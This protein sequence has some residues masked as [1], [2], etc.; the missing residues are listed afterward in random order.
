[1]RVDL[2]SDVQ[3]GQAVLITRGQLAGLTGILIDFRGSRWVI[4]PQDVVDGVLCVVE[5]ECCEIKHCEIEYGAVESVD[6]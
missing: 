3:W 1:M 2:L 5:S 4:K 6:P